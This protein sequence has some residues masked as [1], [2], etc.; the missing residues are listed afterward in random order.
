MNSDKL[1]KAKEQFE[2]RTA[3]FKSLGHDRWA[4]A[5]FVAGS[6]AELGGPVLDVGTGKG[7]LAMALAERGGDVVSVDINEEDQTLAAFMAEEAGQSGKVRFL[8]QDAASL[9]FP[10]GHFGACAMMDVLHHLERGAPVLSEMARV[11]K[12]GGTMIVADFSPEGFDLVARVHASEGQA[13]PRGPVT[14]P[15]AE[16]FLEGIGLEPQVTVE[17]EFQRVSLFRK[18]C[19]TFAGLTRP[20]L[21]RALEAFAK[22]WLAHDGCWFLAAEERFGIEVALE[23]DK[24]SWARFAPVEARRIMGVLAISEGGG[25]EALEQVLKGRMYSL[26][27]PQSTEWSPAKDKLTFTMQSCRVQEARQK[28][29]LPDFPCKPVGEVEFEGFAGAVD[30]RIR[31]RCLHCP[32]D[33]SEERGCAWEFTLEREV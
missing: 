30:P 13:H 10:D 12:P 33:P 18:P 5:R 17:A 20:A 28:K 16:G 31:V 24:V 9:P 23:L 1:L 15:W 32:P 14:A 7:L 25:L 6:A 3:L 22:C 11:L 27:N 8:L 2:A 19:G 21:Q 26:L 29:G 4:A